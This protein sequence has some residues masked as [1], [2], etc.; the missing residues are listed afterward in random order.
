MKMLPLV[1]ELSLPVIG[2]A[3]FAA[4]QILTKQPG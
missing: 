4:T 1:F 3:D 2:T